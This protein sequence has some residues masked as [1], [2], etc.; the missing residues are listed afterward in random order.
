MYRAVVGQ[1]CSRLGVCWP[2]GLGSPQSGV[3]PGL[4]GVIC[5]EGEP[6]GGGRSQLRLC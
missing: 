6:R 2:L 1:A 3:R 4:M 5:L